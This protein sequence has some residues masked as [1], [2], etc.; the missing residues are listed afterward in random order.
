MADSDLNIVETRGPGRSSAAGDLPDKV[1]RRYL[2]DDRGG[3]GVGY[4]VD[5]RAEKPAFRDHGR[6]LTTDRN[7]PNVI[8]DMVA[9][10]QHR[11]WTT[12]LVRGQTDFRREVWRAASALGLE[13]RGYQP[14]TRDQQDLARARTTDVPSRP[15]PSTLR[16]P[17]MR[18]RVVEAVVRNRLTDPKERARILA[19]A[20]ANLAR[21]LERDEP[22][23]RRGD[24]RPRQRVR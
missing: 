22:A 9:I 12:L 24:R 16:D 2:A 19:A 18:L 10:A 17:G 15:A 23:Q 5:A 3:P 4:F 11:G 6:R 21:W 14:T 13:V 7:D 8:R 1:K 20:R